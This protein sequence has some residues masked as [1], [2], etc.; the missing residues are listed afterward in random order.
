MTRKIAV[1]IKRSGIEEISRRPR[2]QQRLDAIARAKPFG[3]ACHLRA[4]V[5]ARAQAPAPGLPRVSEFDRFEVDFV[6][7]AP[8]HQERIF[9][10]AAA[11]AEWLGYVQ[12]P[13]KRGDA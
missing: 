2:A 13:W 7:A 8:R 10:Q 4:A 11:P 3:H 6:S 5:K 1:Q 9:A 12:A